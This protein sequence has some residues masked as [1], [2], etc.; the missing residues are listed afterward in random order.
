MNLESL[1]RDFNPC[2]FIVH[3]SL[4]T[5][6]TL[7]ALRL[8]NFI[9]WPYWAIF[10][11]LW[12][13][14]CTAILGA[15]VGAIVWCRYPH[16]RLEGDAYTQFKAMLISLALH[17]ILLMFELLACDKLTSDRHLWVLVFIPLI[18]GSVVS[19]GACVWAVKHDR[20]F[21]LELFLAVNA[22][23]FVS[24]PLKL[25]KFVYWHWDVVF[26]PMWIV[27]CLSLVSVL[28]NIIFCGIMMRTP[29]VSLQQ[30]KAALN[31]AVG[32]ICTVLPL[33]CFQ[34]VICDKLDGE[35]KFPYIVVFSPLLV[36]ILALII[37]SFTAKGG[38]MWWFGIRKSFSQFLLSAM[39]FLQ[40]YGNISYHA[41]THSGNAGQSVP[42]DATSSSTSTG[43]GSG[44]E[45]LHEFGKHD[46]KSKKAAKNDILKPVVPFVSIDL[47]D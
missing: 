18:F 6:V 34:V 23:Q 2:K 25:D 36:S 9:D 16:Y 33:L 39:P 41:E 19:V 3:C 24:L 38:N 35:L 13:W 44:S 22:L 12:I 14:K 47:P 15:I 21:E 31:A 27:I 32:N 40:E 17:L 42:L 5:F 20:S 43:G 10:T 46:K 37:L 1:F 11:P 26:V 28:Y 4:F 30:K 45:Q 29:E 8:D 7:F